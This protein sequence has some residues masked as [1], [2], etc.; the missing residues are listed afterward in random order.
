[1]ERILRTELEIADKRI[2]VL[3]STIDSYRVITKSLEERIE[4]IEISHKLDIK[5]NYIKK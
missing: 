1:M 5:L 4:A 3:E 2:I